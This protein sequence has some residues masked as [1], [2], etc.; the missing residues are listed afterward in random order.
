MT[1][2]GTPTALALLAAAAWAVPLWEA[3]HYGEV[4]I[5]SIVT[6]GM[7]TAMLAVWPF[8]TG[9]RLRAGHAEKALMC[10][11]CHAL[12]WPTEVSFGFCIHCGSSR[13]AVRLIA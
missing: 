5:L 3:V 9:R 6:A 11:D 1:R 12:R 4:S 8:L 10:R 7:F 2:I 13:P